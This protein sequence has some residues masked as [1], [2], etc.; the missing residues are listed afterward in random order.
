[1]ARD[2]GAPTDRHDNPITES[3]FSSLTDALAG[4]K[5]IADVNTI[6]GQAVETKDGTVIIP[7]SKLSVGFAFGG[8][9]GKNENPMA[10]SLG[11]GGGICLDPVAFLVVSNGESRLLYMKSQ[12]NAEVNISSALPNI[13]EMILDKFGKPK[14]DANKTSLQ[15]EI[16]KELEA[17][18]G[19]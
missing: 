16:L 5:T 15:D 4:I 14:S 8:V 7:I 3:M 18:E 13:V 19:Q 9:N 11:G 2:K 6:V 10:G 1:M 17:T 12:N